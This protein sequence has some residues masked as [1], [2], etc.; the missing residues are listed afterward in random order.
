MSETIYQKLIIDADPKTI[1]DALTT[2]KGLS[3]WWIKDCD[4]N[5]EIGSVSIFRFEGYP[6]T[7]MKVKKLKKNKLLVWKCIGGDKEWIGTKLS[8]S[9][10]EKEKGCSLKF[11]HSKWKKQSNFYASCNFHWARH[12]IMLQNYC[13]TGISALNILKE[14]EEI[15]KVK[16]V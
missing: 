12:F 4:I 14:K 2:K 1:F 15:K 5:T 6:S 8:F 13:E 3:S 16:S 7:E 9:I 10:K 11:K